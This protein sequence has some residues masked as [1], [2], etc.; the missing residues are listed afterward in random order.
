MSK[1]TTEMC[2]DFLILHYKKNGLDTQKS[3]WKRVAKYK[4]NNN[5]WVR[6]FAN[7]KIGI[8]SLVEKDNS[9]EIFEKKL[10]VE[11]V[12]ISYFK[13]FSKEEVKGAKSI[14]KKLIKIRERYDDEQ[15]ETLFNSKEFQLFKS[16][17]PSQFTFC[18]PEDTYENIE[19]NKT[20]GIDS[21]M[22]VRKVLGNDVSFDSLNV[23]FEDR[24]TDDIDIYTSHIL[25]DQHIFPEW[26]SYDDEY[27]LS[28]Y[29]D[30]SSDEQKKVLESMTVK[31]FVNY[32]FEMGF[33]YKVGIYGC[34]FEKE[35]KSYI[36]KLKNEPTG[37][38][39]CP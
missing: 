30:I 34:M 20:N 35:I 16:A 17:I 21:P 22:L 39:N 10:L 5:N 28:I 15:E 36:K 12:K 4:D 24:N 6:N 14:V 9:L 33:E 13:T 19:E 8:I 37:K 29:H 1:I 23:M 26:L 11:P 32:L 31:D 2:K 38:K 27:H 3:D 18:F 7:D 25:T